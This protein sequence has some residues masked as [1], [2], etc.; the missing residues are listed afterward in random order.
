MR[1]AIKR[2]VV[3]RP[4]PSISHPET[5]YC[6]QNKRSKSVRAS[7]LVTYTVFRPKQLDQL[8]KAVVVRHRC[9][10]DLHHHRVGPLDPILK[11][12]H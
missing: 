10:P 8:P 3:C 1:A 4:M 6:Q 12:D 9:R 11:L 7:K 2:F 5:A